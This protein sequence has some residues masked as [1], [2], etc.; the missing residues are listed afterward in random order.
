LRLSGEVTE[1]KIAPIVFLVSAMEREP[2]SAS[3]ENCARRAS[4]PLLGKLA[5]RNLG[6]LADLDNIRNWRPFGMLGQTFVASHLKY[7]AGHLL[8][9]LINLRTNRRRAVT[10]RLVGTW[11][12]TL[13]ILIS[14]SD[15]YEFA[16]T[17]RCCA[18][19]S[20]R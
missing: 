5:V 10:W 16:L 9:R 15:F 8:N 2:V 7:F 13:K 6:R 18:G 19:G 14:I 4:L 1:N 11:L 12:Q 3:T 17:T 20:I